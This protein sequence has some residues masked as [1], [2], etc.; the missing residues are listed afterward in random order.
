MAFW[1]LGASGIFSGGASLVGGMLQRSSAKREAKRAWARNEL[2][3]SNQRG[4][5]SEQA[6]LQRDWEAGQASSA[7]AFEEGQAAKQMQ[8][9][10]ASNAKQMEFQRESAATQMGFQ[11]DMSNTAHQREVS[12]LRA[13]GLNPIL[14]GTGGMGSSTPVGSAPVGASSA[15]SM[16]RGSKGSSSAPGGASASGPMAQILDYITPAIATA[17][18]V[19]KTVADISKTTAETEKVK[20]ETGYVLENTQLNKLL[21]ASESE[22]PNLLK[23]QVADFTESAA[24]KE[25]QRRSKGPVEIEHIRSQMAE[26]GSRMLVQSAQATNYGASTAKIGEETSMLETMRYFR[27]KITDLDQSDLGGYMK[28]VPIDLVK[29]FLLNFLPKNLQ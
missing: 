14:S 26:L 17:M 22:R 28:D 2:S 7:M 6:Q 11:R 18:T 3:A 23:S 15:G 12:D 24:F 9:Q 1:D 4:W 10:E 13:A 21:Q 27:K 5:S 19:G 29:G 16:A 20:A 8:F 25:W